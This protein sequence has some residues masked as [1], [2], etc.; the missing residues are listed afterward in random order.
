MAGRENGGRV[1]ASELIARLQEHIQQHGDL[2]V[3]EAIEMREVNKVTFGDGFYHD[4][5]VQDVFFLED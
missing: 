2:I 1:K 5:K 3:L 4:G